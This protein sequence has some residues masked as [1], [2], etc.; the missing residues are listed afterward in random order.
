MMGFMKTRARECRGV[1]TIRSS[2]REEA[3]TFSRRIN[4]SLLTSAATTKIGPTSFPRSAFASDKIYGNILLRRVVV[5]RDFVPVHYVPKR[6][7][8]IGAFVL[9]LQI[10]SV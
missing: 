10:V 1:R 6:F 4:W 8:I 2:R 3:Q 5:F 7:Q 9:I